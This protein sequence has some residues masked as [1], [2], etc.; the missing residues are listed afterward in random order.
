[1]LISFFV[2]IL[3]TKSKSKFFI[4]YKSKIVLKKYDSL[5]L[6][7]NPSFVKIDVE[8]HDHEV[9]YGMKKTI[10]KYKPIFLIEYN[11]ENFK[12]IFKEL[13]NFYNCFIYNI[14]EKKM[15][16]LTRTEIKSLLSG[17]NKK[18]FFFK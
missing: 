5:N 13:K 3:F 4:L 1:M 11:P 12:K 16:I 18:N 6:N 15:N 14:F 10:K 17:E 7:I 9:I 2:K 8:G